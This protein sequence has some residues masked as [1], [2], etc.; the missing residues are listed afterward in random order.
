M[1]TE[2]Q[3][4]EKVVALIQT[5]GKETRIA[6]H[7][8]VSGGWFFLVEPREEFAAANAY[9]PPT[10]IVRA[11]DG[12]VYQTNGSSPIEHELRQV[13]MSLGTA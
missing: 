8:A 7:K 2:K 12:F 5:P 1:I 6:N 11:N 13:G 4:T 10:I 3:A 9:Y